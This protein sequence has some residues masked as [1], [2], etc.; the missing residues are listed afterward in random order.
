M[1]GQE[2]YEVLLDRG[3]N[4]LFHANSVRTSISQLRLGGLASR[5]KVEQSQL[6]QTIQI[7][8]NLDRSLGIWGD[9]FLDTVDIHHHISDRNKY[10]PVLFEMNVEI[11]LNLPAASSV[12]ITR[13][14]PTNW[15][16]TTPDSERYFLD[17]PS[18]NTGLRVGEFGHMLV[19]RTPTGVI[20]FSDHLQ[21][22]VLDE[23]RLATG[24]SNEHIAAKAALAAAAQHGNVRVNVVRRHCS[25]CRCTSSY[26]KKITRIPWF[27]TE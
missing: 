11:L 8:D 14:N 2:V 1:T 23:P 17:Q 25:P 19:I 16:P 18:L 7:S 4:R 10:G 20:P 26:A 9:V 21:R 27:F 15:Q 6:P 13:S 5:Q 22:I 3:V 24:E 12:L